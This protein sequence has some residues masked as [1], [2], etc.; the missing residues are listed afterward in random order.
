MLKTIRFDGNLIINLES[1]TFS[2]LSNLNLLVLQSNDL[3]II[4][5]GTFSNLTRL[6]YLD[7][8]YNEI[9]SIENEAF[10][11]LVSLTHLIL[12]HNKLKSIG[13]DLFKTLINL[14]HLII[15]I[16][17]IQYLTNLK[18]LDLQMN[19]ITNFSQNLYN[20]EILNLNKNP[21]KYLNDSLIYSYKNNVMLQELYL[22]EC[23]INFVGQNV[24][25]LYKH[26]KLL[27][28]L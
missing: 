12:N 24:F 13:L 28:K 14:K 9:V 26:M 18:I 27:G 10:S 20:L 2:E 5:N 7:L 17:N 8:S 23:Q 16:I 15:K 4:S 6:T 11:D 1:N 3:S 21:I 25:Q 19:S 22:D